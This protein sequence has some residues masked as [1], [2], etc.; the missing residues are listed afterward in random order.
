MYTLGF[1]RSADQERFRVRLKVEI[2]AGF[3]DVTAEASAEY[4]RAGFPVEDLTDAVLLEY[5]NN[6]AVMALLPYLRQAIADM[7]QR[8]FG[9]P[10]LMPVLQRGAVSFSIAEA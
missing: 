3:G 2:V 9:S 5:A 7:T 1:E 4:R 8:V 6:V 10:L